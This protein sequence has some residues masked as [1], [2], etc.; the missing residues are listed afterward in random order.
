MNNNT[1]ADD[2]T[3]PAGETWQIDQVM[4]FAYQTGSTTTSTINDVRIQIWNGN[5]M[6]GGTVIWGGLD[7]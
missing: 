3:I 5:P 7:N 1:M 6:S 2:F 4:T